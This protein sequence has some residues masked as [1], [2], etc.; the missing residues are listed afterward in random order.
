MY[1]CCM[2]RIDEQAKLTVPS[3][4]GK[5]QHFGQVTPK[6]PACC[7]DAVLSSGYTVYT[8]LYRF[9]VSPPRW[10]WLLSVHKNTPPGLKRTFGVED[11]GAVQVPSTTNDGGHGFDPW[12][13]RR[14]GSASGRIRESCHGAGGPGGKP[15][16]SILL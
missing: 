8:E 7:F 1:C 10:C 12:D 5:R 14:P 11:T 4:G 9:R 3:L 16:R 6:L 15:L 13:S 2:W